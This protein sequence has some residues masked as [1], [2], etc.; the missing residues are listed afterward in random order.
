ML[1]LVSFIPILWV[2]SEHVTING[3]EDIQGSLV[4]LSLLV[5]IGGVV[6]SWFIG[7]KLP[8]LEYNNQKV[9]AA[10][11][12]DLVLGEDDK[13]N[14]AQPAYL[15][16]LFVGIRFN[17]QRLFL[18]YGYFDIWRISYI[19]VMVIVPFLVMGPPLFT[20]AIML[21]VVIRVADAF[22]QVQDSFSVFLRNWT[23]I[24]EL[25]SIHKRLAEFES[26]LNR[27]SPG[28]SAPGGPLKI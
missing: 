7:A 25:R 18:H 12:K 17:Y 11:R 24:T 9:E 3:L 10:F 28:G 5:S 15:W 14:H 26:N 4:W 23:T 21:G 27:Y 13:V 8:G 16:E 6:L 22:G 20:G 1:K 19:Q 2:L